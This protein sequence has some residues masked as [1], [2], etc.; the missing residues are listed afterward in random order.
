MIPKD[1]LKDIEIASDYLH[2]HPDS[3]VAVREQTIHGTKK[4]EGVR[5]FLE[6]IDDMG[7][8]L[9]D[10]VIGDRILGKASALLCCH[11]QT[12]GVYAPRGTKTAI[13]TLVVHG[14]PAQVDSII[15][16]ITN[17]TGN[18]LCP[19]EQLLAAVE[20]PSEAYRLLREKLKM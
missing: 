17:R 15:S 7:R 9:S 4:G 12:R 2:A 13:A 5:P 11:I 16:H 1:V 19:F 6:I 20:D 3:I 14:I 18:G 8:S 10:C